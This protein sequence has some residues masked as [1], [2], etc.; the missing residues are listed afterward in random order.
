MELLVVTL[1][2]GLSIYAYLP[3]FLR[4]SLI[5]R[6]YILYTAF[7]VILSCRLASGLAVFV[8]S[9]Y[10]SAY[11]TMVHQLNADRIYQAMITLKAC[12]IKSK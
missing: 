2:L 10:S 1:I 3:Y 6:A 7:R 11:W 9:K 5:R 12:W 4:Y 8:S